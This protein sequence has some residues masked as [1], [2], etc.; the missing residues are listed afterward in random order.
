GLHE[1]GVSQGMALA[2]FDNDGDLDVV[3][4]NLNGG[5]TLYRN[6]SAAPRVAV[7]LKGR[8]PNTRG[9]GAKINVWGGPVRQS[10]E[11]MCGGRY[12]C[13]DD[14]VRVFAA[15]S[16]T[17]QL[18]IEVNWRSGARSL[19]TNVQPNHLYEIEEMSLVTEKSMVSGQSSVAGRTDSP[20]AAGIQQLT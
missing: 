1:E 17:N 12:L 6:N 13:G 5:A 4:N 14:N 20:P 8:A 16:L 15:R 9:I 18:T 7:R 2:D 11:M 19:I 10:Q 3:I